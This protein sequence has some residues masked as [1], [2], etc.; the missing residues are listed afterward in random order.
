ML[1]EQDHGPGG[2]EPVA[3]AVVPL[4]WVMPTDALIPALDAISLKSRPRSRPSV[5]VTPTSKDDESESPPP[6]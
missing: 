5:T 4:V 2:H 3:P 6:M 1:N